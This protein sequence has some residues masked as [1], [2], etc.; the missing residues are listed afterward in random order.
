MRLTDHRVAGRK[1]Q[2]MPNT[3]PPRLVIK[4]KIKYLSV[5]NMTSG[6]TGTTERGISDQSMDR[7]D[8][9]RHTATATYSDVTNL[10][11]PRPNTADGLHRR[12]VVVWPNIVA[13][14][15]CFAS[16]TK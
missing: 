3:N 5:T 1:R 12:Y 6:R 14:H 2:L 11:T 10:A 9:P 8:V 13:P 15:T 16:Q 4:A 7:E